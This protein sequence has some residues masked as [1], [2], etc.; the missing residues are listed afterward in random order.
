MS[1]PRRAAYCCIA[2]AWFSVEYFWC[3]VDIRTYCAARTDLPLAS[4]LRPVPNSRPTANH[5]NCLG[6]CG[7]A[8]EGRS[9]ATS[10]AEHE[11]SPSGQLRI[12]STIAAEDRQNVAEKGHSFSEWRESWAVHC[13]HRLYF[14]EPVGHHPSGRQNR[15]GLD[16]GGGADGE[17]L[18]RRDQW[19]QR[20]TFGC[21]HPP[22]GRGAGGPPALSRTAADHSREEAR[23][24]AQQARR[25]TQADRFI[26][27][28]RDHTVVP[29]FSK[30]IPLFAPKNSLFPEKNSLFR[31]LGNLSASH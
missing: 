30:A 23:R 7:R 11:S 26:S 17:E 21:S 28:T 5:P 6:V 29:F 13:G 25:D 3:S 16:W 10:K 20:S 24:H 22:F 12:P 1:M 8:R 31:R 4:P 9:C 15:H 27:W 18:V 2:S 19:S 14:A